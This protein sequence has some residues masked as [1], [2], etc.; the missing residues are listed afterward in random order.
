MFAGLKWVILPIPLIPA[1]FLTAISIKEMGWKVNNE[2]GGWGNW[3]TMNLLFF[4][5]LY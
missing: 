2:K 5:Y 1:L 4:S 3:C